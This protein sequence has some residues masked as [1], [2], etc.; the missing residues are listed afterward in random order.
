M[1]VTTSHG[2]LT[3]FGDQWV[4]VHIRPGERL[5]ESRERLD[6]P[7][8][9]DGALDGAPVREPRAHCLAP[10][11]VPRRHHP[12]EDSPR[13]LDELVGAFLRVDAVTG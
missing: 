2:R 10:R 4:N 8:G 3:A 5:A 6:G 13:R 11:S 1:I 12:G 7:A 9:A